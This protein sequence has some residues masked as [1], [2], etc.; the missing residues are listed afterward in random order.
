MLLTG[1]GLLRPAQRA[2]L[3]HPSGSGLGVAAPARADCTTV[4]PAAPCATHRAPCSSAVDIRV[5][6]YGKIMLT[7]TLHSASRTAD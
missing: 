2:A 6:Q 1:W 5:H 4:Q 3:V 7:F